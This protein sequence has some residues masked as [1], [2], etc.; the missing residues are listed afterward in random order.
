MDTKKYF[1]RFLLILSILFTYSTQV[2]AQYGTEAVS[3]II[4]VYD[5]DTFRADIDSL[6]SIVGKNISIRINGIDTPEIRGRCQYE[7][8]LA[9]KARD[10]VKKRLFSAREIKLSNI[11]R[12]K[13]FRLV[14]DIVVDNVSLG[15]ELIDHKL[16]YEYYGGKKLSW[17][18]NPL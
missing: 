15:Q 12:G 7:K 13:Y 8:E 18:N 6:P 1:T 17:C 4:S 16:A 2:K 3:R 5:G 9:L 11:Q 14:A 10:F